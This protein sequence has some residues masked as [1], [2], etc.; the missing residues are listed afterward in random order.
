MRMS[1]NDKGFTLI[2]LLMV[3]FMLGL[4]LMSLYSIFITSKRSSGN[5][6][7]VV[8]VQ[9]NLR[10]AMD[11][12]TRDLRN[13]GFMISQMRDASLQWQSTQTAPNPNY[14]Q[15]IEKI[16]DN[17]GSISSNTLWPTPD[18]L[19]GSNSVHADILVMNSASPFTFFSVAKIVTP[20][21]G[22]TNPFTVAASTSDPDVQSLSGFVNGDNVRIYNPIWHDEETNLSPNFLPRAQGG[23]GT[24]FQ[25][26]SLGT[27]T[28]QLTRPVGA[29]DNDPTNTNFRKGDI[30][31]KTT[32][33]GTPYVSSVQYCLGPVTNCP[34]TGFPSLPAGTVCNN[35]AS[36]ETMCLLRV[37]NAETDVI[38]T[39][40]SGLQ[41]TYLLDDGTEVSSTNP[42]ADLGAI[43]AVRVT[44]TGQTANVENLSG[45]PT[46]TQ[47]TR[48]LMS[49][50]KLQNRFLLK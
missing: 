14:T 20:Q 13:A 40:I 49:L 16:L 47:K 10:I 50:V 38:A 17:S 42:P 12:I 25:V 4:V 48:T 44:I 7:E 26:V 9:Q 24:V 15:P 18:A 11:N 33:T 27:T 46:G 45:S 19:V 35:G 31:T 28:I 6:D 30:I 39:K 23:K 21:T 37:T 29:S 36:D 34:P 3:A 5:Q 1:S 43:R 8:D 2:E 41:F 22:I 32:V